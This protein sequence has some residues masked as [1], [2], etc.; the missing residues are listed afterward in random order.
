MHEKALSRTLKS[1]AEGEN[2]KLIALAV[3]DG[4]PLPLAESR[5]YLS[6]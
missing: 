2:M 3:K 4:L 1:D 6:L 5:N